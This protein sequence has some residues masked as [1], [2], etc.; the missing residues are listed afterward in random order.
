[1][2]SMTM[3]TVTKPSHAVLP[4]WLLKVQSKGCER[5]REV[6]LPSG[7]EEAW[8]FTKIQPI[9]RAKFTPADVSADGTALHAA[10]TFGDDAGVEVVFVNG[11]FAPE[12]SKTADLTPGLT[13]YTFGEATGHAGEIARKHYGQLVDL[14]K[15]GFAAWNTAEASDGVFVH[16]ARSATVEKPIHFLFISVG[17]PT[18]T[19]SHPRILVD[20][21]AN[22][23]ATFV[24]SYVGE[25]NAYLTNAVSE[26]HVG[27]HA[28]I[29]HCKLQQESLS[30][31]HTASMQVKIGKRRNS[32]ATPSA[33]AQPSAATIWPL[34]S[35][36]RADMPRSTAW[37]CSAATS[38]AT[39][40]R[41]SI[42]KNQTVQVTNCTS[43]C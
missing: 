30:A 15:H 43:T 38:T 31:Y 28:R 6:G 11:Q 20:A 16:V 1:M 7:K 14:H 13:V 8:R 5:F 32:S 19:V 24:E 25:G 12:L 41:C 21:E 10:Y 27:D 36:G 33:S 17:G 40:T 23:E 29:D 34:N 22:C 39:T 4:D 26:Y 3:P 2:K 35:T 37:F 18:S 9:L 42:T